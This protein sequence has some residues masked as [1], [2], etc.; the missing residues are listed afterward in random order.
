ML[1][2]KELRV[3]VDENHPIEDCM[4]ACAW[5]ELAC[6][7]ATETCLNEMKEEKL[8]LCLQLT[9]DCAEICWTTRRFMADALLAAPALVREQL[10]SC[11]LICAACAAECRRHGEFSYQLTACSR[12][13]ARCEQ[14]CR[15]MQLRVAQLD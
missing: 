15:E 13:C 11:A 9:L 1:G 14:L 4:E 12:T 6:L 3:S 8:G 2:L 7:A 5:C 10:D